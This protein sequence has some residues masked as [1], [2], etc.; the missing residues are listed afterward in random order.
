MLS[1]QGRSCIKTLVDFAGIFTGFY[2]IYHSSVWR[3]YVCSK[4][5]WTL[6]MRNKSSL[7]AYFK[8]AWAT[9]QYEDVILNTLP[10]SFSWVSVSRISI[11]R[12]GKSHHGIFPPIAVF[13]WMFWQYKVGRKIHCGV[14]VV[15][16]STFD[17]RNTFRNKEIIVSN[18]ADFVTLLEVLI[19]AILINFLRTLILHLTCELH[20]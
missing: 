12:I 6:P 3:L 4:K 8:F 17:G 20:S 15:V 11:T 16:H 13:S 18:N 14:V 5:A 10:S 9:S 7:T 19:H 2:I 1:V